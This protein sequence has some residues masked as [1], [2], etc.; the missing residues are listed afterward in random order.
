MIY[1]QHDLF[2]TLENIT[3]EQYKTQDIFINY[4][5]SK[6]CFGDIIIAS[7]TKG[8]CYLAF[9][10]FDRKNAIE[11]LKNEFPKALFSQQIDI[12]QQNA[13]SIFE[14]EQKES[15]P[16]K[17]HIKGT[18]FQIKIWKELLK[19]PAG[20]LSTYGKIAYKIE[21]PKAQRAV[22]SAIGKN[23][24]A[25]IIPCHRVIKSSGKFGDYRWGNTRKTLIIKSELL[26]S[27]HYFYN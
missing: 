5:F 21:N 26:T 16:I 20:K 3:T 14:K 13:L 11:N 23:P 18:D 17:L 8:V 22:G 25:F 7:T 12:F 10:D 15:P 9:F 6:S 19:I 2:V 4:S 27:R 1:K 24:V